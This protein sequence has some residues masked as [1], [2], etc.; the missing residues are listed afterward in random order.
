[1]EKQLTKLIEEATW[2]HDAPSAETLARYLI[3]KGVRVLQGKEGVT[4]PARPG[5]DEWVFTVL[6]PIGDEEDVYTFE[7]EVQDIICSENNTWYAVDEFGEVNRIG[8]LDCV[9][10]EDLESTIADVKWE[11]EI[12]SKARKARRK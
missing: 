12:N 4:R 1:M 11:F 10:Y 6:P 2:A 5:I 7:W 8:S 3:G 9:L